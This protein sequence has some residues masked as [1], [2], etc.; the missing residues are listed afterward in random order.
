MELAAS[1]IG[2]LASTASSAVGALTGAGAT[3][4]GAAAGAGAPLNLLGFTAP[5][6]GLFSTSNVLSALSGVA[7]I[8]GLSATRAETD[9]RAR[10]LESAAR[11]AEREVGLEAVRFGERRTSLRRA[12]IEELGQ[13]DVQAAASGVDL[14]FG[15]VAQARQE[16]VDE[17]ERVLGLEAQTQTLRQSRLLERAAEL[18]MSARSTRSAGRL[19]EFGL[20]G[21]G[22]V[23]IARRG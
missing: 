15:T 6:A 2:W 13:R 9:T 14:G 21:Q 1:A 16:S 10:A 5:A 22:A 8:A 18:R 7:T 17:A 19:R 12:L 11:D 3:A 4:A 23:S 20:L